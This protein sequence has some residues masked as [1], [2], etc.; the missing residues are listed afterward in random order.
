MELRQAGLMDMADH[1]GW[2]QSLGRRSVLPSI[3]GLPSCCWLSMRVAGCVAVG[4][5]E[6]K[7]DTQIGSGS[8]GAVQIYVAAE[9][10]YSIL[11]AA[12]HG[13]AGESGTSPA[14]VGDL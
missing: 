6:R 2:R 14:V 1:R 8:P 7:R 13:A 11:D 12:Q 4:L 9:R 3:G 10:L 5:G